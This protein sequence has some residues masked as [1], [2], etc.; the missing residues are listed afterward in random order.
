MSELGVHDS[1]RNRRPDQVVRQD[2]DQYYKGPSGKL[3]MTM[4]KRA[5]AGSNEDDLSDWTHIQREGHA[6][7]VSGHSIHYPLKRTEAAKVF[8]R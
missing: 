8:E 1:S 4:Y 7:T 2:Y 5:L 3:K 6:T